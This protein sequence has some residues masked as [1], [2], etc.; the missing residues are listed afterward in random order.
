MTENVVDDPSNVQVR[1]G[2]GYLLLDAHN[3]L[4]N[5]AVRYWPNGFTQPDLMLEMTH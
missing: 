5:T 4:G 3:L 1:K 2:N